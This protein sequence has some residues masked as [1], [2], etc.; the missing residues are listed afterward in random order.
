MSVNNIGRHL[1]EAHVLPFHV[2]SGT[3][4]HHFQLYG[5]R[6]DSTV[7]YLVDISKEW[8]LNLSSNDNHVREWRARGRRLNSASAV[9]WHTVSSTGVMVW[10][11]IA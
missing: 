6:R 3:H 5:V 9:T 7:K 8:R 11:T 1:A 10:D 2:L 4:Y